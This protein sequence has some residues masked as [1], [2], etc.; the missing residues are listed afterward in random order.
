MLPFIGAMPGIVAS[1][2]PITSLTHTR[3]GR[4]GSTSGSPTI[5]LMEDIIAGDLLIFDNVGTNS[6]APAA[7]I[8]AGFT[9]VRNYTFWDFMGVGNG[10]RRVWAY[11]VAIGDESGSTLTGMSN[12]N[13]SDFINVVKVRANRAINGVEFI[14]GSTSSTSGNP[15]AVGVTV[16]SQTDPIVTLTG[17]Y[18]GSGNFSTLTRT[19][20]A[21]AAWT[22]G[23]STAVNLGIGLHT[24][25]PFT[26][27]SYDMGDAGQFQSITAGAFVLT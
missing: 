12:S 13:Y 21:T 17:A 15:A 9:S 22:L 20:T 4:E 10:V 3:V 23:G 19:P 16:N 26:N 6:V 7:V 25:P 8:P 5:V 27:V 14:G 11:K 1:G 18:K 2:G 24:T